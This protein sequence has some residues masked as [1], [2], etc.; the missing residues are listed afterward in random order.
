M[1]HF[2]DDL[3]LGAA[4]L[5]P[6]DP[7]S[8]YPANG[9]GV[10][11]L[12]RVYVWDAVPLALNTANIAALQTAAAAGALTLAAGTG[13]TR[14]LNSRNEWVINLDVPRAVAVTAIAGVTTRSYVVTGYDYAGQ[15]MSESIPTVAASSTVTGKKAFKQILSVTVDGATAANVSVGTSDVLGAP[16]AFT[17][18]GYLIAIHWNN[19]QAV[20]AAT[21]VV[22]DATAA[23]ATTGDVRGTLDPSSA[24]DGSKR[25]VVAIAMPAI[26]SGP[27][28]TRAGAYGVDQNLAAS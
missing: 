5:G 18:K 6:N 25:L 7:A 17:D 24:C 8:P 19:T 15:K 26:A 23:S 10:G 3:Y 1:T 4:Q 22:A 27:N 20:D 16:V 12:G 13:T 9:W 14:I 11:P 28:A 2:S 21:T